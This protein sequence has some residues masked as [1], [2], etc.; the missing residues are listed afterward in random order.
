MNNILRYKGHFS[1]I[2]YSTK[3]KLL[4]GKIEGIND[5]VNF[6]SDSVDNI[7]IEFHNAVDDYLELCKE[8]GQNPD[9]VYS[10]TFNV[11][12]SPELHKKIAVCAYKENE[13]L[14]NIVEKAINEY[15][16]SVNVKMI[17][18]LWTAINYINCFSLQSSRFGSANCSREIYN[19]ASKGVAYV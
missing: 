10:G 5:L 11:R 8:A 12:I 3:D 2:E 7:E 16:E 9:K 13:T 14:N 6:E 4:Y 19:K 15:V 1:K 17:N 18:E